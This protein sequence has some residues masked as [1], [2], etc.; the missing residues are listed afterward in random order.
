M[1]LGRFPASRCARERLSASSG[2][3]KPWFHRMSY[4]AAARAPRVHL[5]VP[6]LDAFGEGGFGRG[7]RFGWR[8]GKRGRPR[9]E[10][11]GQNEEE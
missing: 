2:V 3:R 6:Q 11:D 5:V 1:D 7:E 9:E 4:P 8:R 10:N